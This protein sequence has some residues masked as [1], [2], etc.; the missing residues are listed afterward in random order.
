MI[1]VTCRS[2][3]HT[4]YILVFVAKKEKKSDVL[5]FVSRKTTLDIQ[6]DYSDCKP[7]MDD[8]LSGPQITSADRVTIPLINSYTYIFFAYIFFL[9]FAVQYNNYIYIFIPPTYIL[10]Q[11]RTSESRPRHGING[12]TLSSLNRPRSVSSMKW[13]R[14]VSRLWD[15][16]N[17]LLILP[18]WFQSL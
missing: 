15:P 8:K 12:S 3:T 9:F 2:Y 13:R 16:F 6:Y 4:H 11:F 5:F 7:S 10:L 1:S 17:T 18:T 14:A